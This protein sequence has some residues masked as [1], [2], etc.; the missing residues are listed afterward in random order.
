MKAKGKLFAMIEKVLDKLR[1]YNKDFDLERVKKALVFLGKDL[2]D[3]LYSFD[4]VLH[5]YPDEDMLIA[6][7][8]KNIYDKGQ[9]SEN[10]VKEVFGNTILQ[11]LHNVKRLE[12]LNYAENDKSSQLEI[13]RKMFLAMAKDI[14]V[15]LLCL[16]DR[17]HKMHHEVFHMVERD[18]VA[19]AKE[20]LDLYVPIAD[21]LGIYT[22][23]TDLEDLA[24][25]YSNPE[26]Y[27]N[28]SE[29]LEKLRKSC[30]ISM[31]LISKKLQ[32]FFK[33]RGVQAEVYGRIK[34]I[35]SIYK[36][37]KRKN[38][39]S[40][41][42]LYDVFAMRV[43]LPAKTDEE[44]REVLDHLYGVL[45]MIHSEW[46][47]I[48]KKFKDY[49]AVPKSNGYR[50]L[51]TVVLGIAP[52]DF[53]Q[54]VEIQIRES[55]MHRD[56][57]Y[58][59]AA[60][61]LYKEIGGNS[62]NINSHM[63]WIRGIDNVHDDLVTDEDVAREFQVDLFKDRIFVLTPRG[64]VK[65]LPQGSIPVDFAYAVHTEVGNKCV[66]AKVDGR[67][68]PLDYELKN[69]EV[70][71]I[72]TR[73]DAIPKIQWLSMVK[74]NF[75]RNRIKAFFSSL[76]KEGN[77]REGK[78]LIN[79]QLARLNK[80]PLDSTYSI[81]K[82]FEGKNL[83]LSE[84]EHLI[85]EVGRGLKLSSDIVKKIFPYE[86]FVS[87]ELVIADLERGRKAAGIKGENLE[88]EILVGGEEGLPLKI[89][90]CCQ[91]KP[92]E[93]I[94][95]YVTRGNSITI[96]NAECILLGALDNERIV[97][98]EW[99]ENLKRPEKIYLVGIRILL[100][101][102]IGM[103]S[104][105]TAIMAQ[106]GVNIRDVSVNKVKTGLIEDYFLLEFDDLDKF[107]HLVD[108]L[109]KVRG[110]LKIIRDDRFKEKTSKMK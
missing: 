57:E 80:P 63:D 49:I 40:V 34:S 31:S 91:P 108:K 65:D 60:H 106:M 23:K 15:V 10:Q 86:R 17:L 79:N 68:V 62:H 9:L 47:P 61:W 42:D 89:A 14:R 50:S 66:M 69:G 87:D 43:I 109:E 85:E 22:V 72:I 102:R 13:L 25:K 54:P 107:D 71:E 53:D 98:A 58:G 73:K 7:L 3:A 59:I 95:G 92:G 78:R 55:N 20:T 105:M 74:S 41:L 110:V 103:M 100:V 82:K 29:Q 1:S 38:L 104:D 90:A 48:S 75:A 8:I 81:L 70:V 46:K 88:N 30:D 11:I 76:N 12:K 97:F 28:I 39:S 6:V 2:P 101:S 94:L 77:I 67:I 64:E 52:K 99:K 35:Y 83:N 19:F 16:V 18:R 4:L 56:A 26:I 93:H 21:R 24:F 5:L 36:K 27:Y 37:L 96:H 32:Q 84:R 44:G 45:G 51:H 33:E